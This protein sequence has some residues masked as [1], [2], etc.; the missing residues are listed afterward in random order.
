MMSLCHLWGWQPTQTASPIH[1]KYLQ[2]IIA[3]WYAVHRHMVAALN[4]CRPPSWLKFWGSGS[5]VES[6]WCD[7]IMV[8]ADSHL[9]LLPTSI[10][11]I[12]K[13]FEHI[14]MPSIGTQY[15]PYTVILTLLGSDVGVLGHLW[16]QND[17]IMSWLRLTATSNCFPYPHQT[18]KKCLI[19][20]TYVNWH[21][22]AALHSFIHSKRLRFW[23]SEFWLTSGCGVEM[24]SLCHVWGW[25][26]T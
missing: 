20:L 18:Y 4:T 24:K 12:H 3:H 21:T 9:K 5:L 2:S 15:Q 6:K 22:V 14:D 10:L 25:Q 13:E 23:G 7:Y 1:L 8:E 11:D 16:S 17:V 19:T 26:P